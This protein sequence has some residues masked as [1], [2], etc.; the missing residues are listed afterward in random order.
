MFDKLV[1]QG[2]AKLIVGAY[3]AMMVLVA[4]LA[5]VA[6]SGETDP[7][8]YNAAV[9]LGWL[10]PASTVVCPRATA[11]P[12]TRPDADAVV[13]R[14]LTHLALV[15]VM[16]I[17]RQKVRARDGIPTAV[18]G[19]PCCEDCLCLVCYSPFAQCQVARQEYDPKHYQFLSTNGIDAV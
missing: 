16:I 13:L 8:L 1:K 15:A 6:I 18:E 14:R 5:V 12:E 9:A 7:A 3:V 17:V 19:D 4:I 2:T 10:A 11:R